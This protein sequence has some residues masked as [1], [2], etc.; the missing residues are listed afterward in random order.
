[1]VGSFQTA[2]AQALLEPEKPMPEGVT[3]PGAAV[4]SQRFAVHRNNVAAGLVKALQSRFPVIEKLVGEE[5]FG[6]M[7][8]AFVAEQPPRSPLLAAYGDEFAAFIAGF[9]PA[10]ELAYLADVARLE[11]AR[12]RAYHA[13]DAMSLDP[14]RFAA[15]DPSVIGDVRVALHPSAQIIR[16][17]YPIVTIWAMNSGERELAPIAS[18]LGEDALVVRPHFE[19]LVRILPPGAAAFLLALSSSC[20]IGEAAEVGL[21]DDPQFDLTGGLAGLIGSGIV[22]EIFLPEARSRAMP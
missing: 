19:V 8:R 4:T 16:S 10:C 20:P 1:M 13:A 15:L 6:A 18:W 17:P 11:A 21:A 5:F 14:T 7:A 12:T 3:T 2:F 9:A 22:S